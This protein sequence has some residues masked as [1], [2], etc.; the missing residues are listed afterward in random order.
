MYVFTRS[1]PVGM[2]EINEEQ[3]KTASNPETDDYF[4]VPFLYTA[5]RR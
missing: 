5:A 3:P 2:F 1:S 4:G